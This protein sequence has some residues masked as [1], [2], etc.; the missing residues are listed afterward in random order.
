MT[1]CSRCGTPAGGDDRVCRT[2]GAPLPAPVISNDNPAETDDTRDRPAVAVAV[3]SGEQTPLEPEKPSAQPE[4]PRPQA[5]IQPPQV[6][7]RSPYQSYVY[8]NPYTYAWYAPSVGYASGG[9]APPTPYYGGY[10]YPPQ[11]PKPAPGETYRIVLAWIVT[12]GSGFGVLGGVL[13]GLLAAIAYAR[14]GLG[15]TALGGFAG[16]VIAPVLGG[17]A[18]I[19]YGIMA[20]LKRPSL[21]F[22]FP[23]WWIFAILTIVA[24]GGEVVIW[25]RVSAPGDAIAVMPA[26]L[27]AGALPALTILAFAGRRL[28]FP[29]TWR[30]V[31]LSLIYGSAIATLIASIL[32]TVAYFVIVLV[33]QSLGFQV[34]YDLNFLQNLNP[35]NP[36]E[37]LVFFFLGSVAA[38]LIE[39]GTKPLGA[40]LV[41]PRLRGP[42]E[43][44]LVGMAAGLGFAVVE[45]WG[46]FGMGQADWVGVAIE[47]IGV[48]LLHGVGAGMGA[49]GWYYLIRGKGISLRWL[50]GFGALAYAVA[51]HGL[52]N[53]SNLL[54][55][56]PT[57]GPLLSHPFYI[58]R[59][60][61]DGGTWVAFGL[62]AVIAVVLVVI[63]GKL[64]NGTT[65]AK[66]PGQA[67]PI[68]GAP[69][70]QD[71]AQRGAR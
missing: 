14:G 11:P 12:I 67:K 23:P 49:L 5:V 7:Q 50:R 42:N 40:L 69:Q 18:G 6:P 56:I 3:A 10:Y 63:T 33:M 55:L 65:S 31:M 17:I 53:A 43:A 13:F 45:T 62:Y 64:A 59:L 22:S 66:R 60:P 52:F 41:M 29:S 16:L 9:Y 54:G 37:A 70:A 32:N 4:P 24:I 38:P 2:C 8:P 61:L 51:Q 20:I 26:F 28:R 36:S 58:G 1:E 15:L 71:L 30:H 44:F 48:G 68:G 35:T 27:M 57:I 19:Y 25:N 39:E 21:R 47:R 34:N 46:Y